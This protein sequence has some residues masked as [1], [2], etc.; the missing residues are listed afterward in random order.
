MELAG[1][2]LPSRSGAG[3]PLLALAQPLLDEHGAALAVLLLVFFS[4]WIA[5]QM[6]VGSGKGLRPLALAVASGLVV[7]AA[8]RV[9]RWKEGWGLPFVG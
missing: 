2:A 9:A 5:A 3:L 1:G 7:V 4:G 8:V 6:R